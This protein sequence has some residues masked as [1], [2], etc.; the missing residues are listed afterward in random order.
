MTTEQLSL[1]YVWDAYCGWCYGFS[2]SL[3]TFHE[4]NLELPVRIVS[5]GLFTGE[6]SQPLTAYPYMPEANSRISQLT[7]AVFG[8]AYEQLLKEGSLVLDSEAAAIG[9]SAL[10]ALAPERA[11]DLASAMQQAFYFNGKS[12]SDAA[13]YLELAST[14]GLDEQQLIEG[15]TAPETVAE[16]H[17]DFE[18]ALKLGARSYPTLLLQ[19]G[20]E[21]FELGGGAMTADKLEARFA[22]LIAHQ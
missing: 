15:L 5:G 1:I 20:D 9:F 22:G 7:G 13:T 19:K 16:A 2:K 8:T 21:I 17:E 6:R 18:I 4:N 12:L 3:R 11:L 10:R 14:Y